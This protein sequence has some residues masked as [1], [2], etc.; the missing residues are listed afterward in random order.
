MKS[1]FNYF[2]IKKM[3]F[4]DTKTLQENRIKCLKRFKAKK[5]TPYETKCRKYMPVQI[6]TRRDIE[7]WWKISYIRCK[8]RFCFI[9]FLAL[10]INDRWPVNLKQCISRNWEKNFRSSSTSASDIAQNF[11]LTLTTLYCKQW[12]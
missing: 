8:T 10:I 4:H 6:W 2:L 7:T 3:L 11:K 9:A 5:A 1:E 12:C